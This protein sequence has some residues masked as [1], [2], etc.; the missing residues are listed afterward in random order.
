ML[1]MVEMD[2][3]DRSR[4]TQWH[5]WYES[6]IRKLLSV[7]GY[8]GAQ[9]FE[10]LAACA[11]PFLAIHDVDDANVFDS[12][13]Y[14]AVGGPAGTGEWRVLMTNWHRNLFAGV[15]RM[16]RVGNDERLVLVD[17]GAVLSA[18]LQ[19]CVTWLDNAG[20]DRSIER[21]GLT[22]LPADEAETGFA[23]T[24]GVMLYRPISDKIS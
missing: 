14:H 3:P 19:A 2:L 15:E 18:R 13:G 1:Y 5:A 8:H 17:G 22:V 21:R 23:Q 10:A 6:H 20:L 11:S 4:E 7:D 16:P 24:H 12:P 9:R